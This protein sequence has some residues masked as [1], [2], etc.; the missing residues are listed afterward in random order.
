MKSRAKYEFLFDRFRSVLKIHG[1][2]KKEEK[3]NVPRNGP[4]WANA[5]WGEKEK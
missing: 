5:R 2:K 3:L 1:E 4:T